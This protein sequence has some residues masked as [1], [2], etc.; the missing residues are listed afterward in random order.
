MKIISMDEAVLNKYTMNPANQIAVA[1]YLNKYL[2]SAQ[3][4]NQKDERSNNII[5]HEMHDILF[6]FLQFQNSNLQS[7]AINTFCKLINCK[8]KDIIVKIFAKDNF[9]I[10]GQL[11]W[12]WNIAVRKQTAILFAKIAEYLIQDDNTFRDGTELMQFQ[13]LT[14][15]LRNPNNKKDVANLITEVTFGD[16]A[17]DLSKHEL[18]RYIITFLSEILCLSSPETFDVIFYSFVYILL[19]PH[20]SSICIEHSGMLNHFYKP[21]PSYVE[22]EMEKIHKT[23]CFLSAIYQNHDP[24]ITGK[25]IQSTIPAVKKLLYIK[26]KF[27]V[28]DAFLTMWYLLKRVEKRIESVLGKKMLQDLQMQLTPEENLDAK[29]DYII[30]NYKSAYQVKYVPAFNFNFKNNEVQNL[31]NWNEK[32]WETPNQIDFY[33]NIFSLFASDK[34][35]AI[36][37]TNL[38]KIRVL[39]SRYLRAQSRNCSML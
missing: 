24:A 34:C 19:K 30:D 36:M 35:Y 26:D 32:A 21:S 5:Y 28:S 8:Q 22:C 10:L 7:L 2:N 6:K 38:R 20:Y 3:T 33:L 37:E 39:G 13:F 27:V 12:S 17:D 23:A 1:K 9:S 29:A 25:L 14:K 31:E 16:I 4:Q 15:Q 18:L 11:L